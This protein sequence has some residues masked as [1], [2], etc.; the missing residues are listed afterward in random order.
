MRSDLPIW[1]LA[2]AAVP[3]TEGERMPRVVSN[4]SALFRAIVTVELFLL[5]ALTMWI[6]WSGVGEGFWQW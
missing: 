5:A 4:E 1:V 3:P 2:A 6:D